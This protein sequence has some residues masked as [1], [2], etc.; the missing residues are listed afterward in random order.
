MLRINNN[1][2]N[3]AC[4]SVNKEYNIMNIMMEYLALLII[5]TIY[6]LLR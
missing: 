3:K 6:K 2:K 5:L 1:H 4:Q